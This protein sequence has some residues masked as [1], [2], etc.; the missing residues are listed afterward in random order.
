MASRTEVSHGD[1]KRFMSTSK[2]R[3]WSSSTMQS[4]SSF[5]ITTV[6]K[7]LESKSQVT[8]STGNSTP[9]CSTQST[10]WSTSLWLT[11]SDMD[12]AH[13]ISPPP[14]RS[15]QA[16]WSKV[17]RIIGKPTQRQASHSLSLH[18]HVHD[19][20][21]IE[22]FM[23]DITIHRGQIPLLGF[24]GSISRFMASHVFYYE[25]IAVSDKCVSS[26]LIHIINHVSARLN[27]RVWNLMSNHHPHLLNICFNSDMEF[28]KG[29]TQFNFKPSFYV[30]SMIIS[31]HWDQGA[32][33]FAAS[34]SSQR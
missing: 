29:L 15:S 27:K 34:M 2:D 11:E 10:T 6:F 32:D 8:A 23:E 28:K 9:H 1:F 21:R 20:V 31:S 25:A 16:S 13:T 26:I 17:T 22:T 24:S 12:E 30:D 3:Y 5:N 33:T 14:T 4:S 7:F 19:H 18:Q